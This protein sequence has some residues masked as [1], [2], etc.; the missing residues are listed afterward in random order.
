MT[1]LKTQ[2]DLS[3]TETCA[4]LN[5]TSPTI[6]KMLGRGELEGYK[7]GRSRRITRESVQRL[8]TGKG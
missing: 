4:I 8:R 1:D 3:V 5:V 6:Y 7:A 2:G